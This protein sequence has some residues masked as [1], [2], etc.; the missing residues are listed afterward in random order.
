MSLKNLEIRK[1]LAMFC[2]AAAHC[3]LYVCVCVFC[4]AC[5]SVPKTHFQPEWLSYSE[6]EIRTKEWKDNDGIAIQC[7]DAQLLQLGQRGKILVVKYGNASSNLA[8]CLEFYRPLTVRAHYARVYDEATGVMSE[9]KQFCPET[10]SYILVG[11]DY[12]QAAIVSLVP[13]G[14]N[15]SS[16]G[17]AITRQIADNNKSAPLIVNYTIEYGEDFTMR[18]GF[19]TQSWNGPWPSQR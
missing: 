4:V 12:G 18:R 5:T 7:L 14:S 3:Y 9:N 8:T 16:G 11:K 17:V 19:H 1:C 10:S 15:S 13:F 6:R 2:N